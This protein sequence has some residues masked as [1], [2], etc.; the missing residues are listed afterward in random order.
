MSTQAECYERVLP[1]STPSGS[2]SAPGSGRAPRSIAAAMTSRASSSPDATRAAVS[3]TSRLA[4]SEES[5]VTARRARD[6]TTGHMLPEAGSGSRDRSIPTAWLTGPSV[7]NRPPTGWTRIRYPPAPRSR[8]ENDGLFLEAR[9]AAA[10]RSRSRRPGHARG[11]FGLC[12]P[13][14]GPLAGCGSSISN[15]GR[16]GEL[17][18]RPGCG[19]G[20]RRSR[21]AR[22]GPGAPGRCGQRRGSLLVSGPETRRDA[23]GR[24]Q[25]REGGGTRRGLRAGDGDGP[26]DR[27]RCASVLA[28][29][30]CSCSA[31]SRSSTQTWVARSSRWRPR[32]SERSSRSGRLASA[33][34]SRSKR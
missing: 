12:D 27:R 22:G 21:R 7:A 24:E 11:R 10:C 4:S 25:L 26:R 33:A 16:C 3:T 23:R 17:A 30:P 6:V 19:E 2:R 5:S 29:G 8:D 18:R 14:A 15:A 13:R 32:D 34:R 9:S 31:S 28:D 1:R 20:A